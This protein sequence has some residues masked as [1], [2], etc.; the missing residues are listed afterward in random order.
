MFL[1]SAYTRFIFLAISVDLGTYI[2]S[3]GPSFPISPDVK[4]QNNDFRNC[5]EMWNGH[6]MFSQLS[7]R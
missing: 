1:V 7:T 3:A 6:L 2:S 4:Y 5:L